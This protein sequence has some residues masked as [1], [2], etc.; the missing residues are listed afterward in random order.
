M[1]ITVDSNVLLSVF[2]KDSLYKRSAALLEKYNSHE[3][4]INDCI[5]LEL[6]VHFE[7]LEKLNNALNTLDVS[8]IEGHGRNYVEILNAWTHYLGN[9]KFVCPSCKQA[10]N[11]VCPKCRHRL[12]F[13]QRILTDFFIGGFALANSAGIITLDP[14]YYKNYFPRLKIFD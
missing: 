5:Y 3:Y 2:A 8:I 1:I 13:R 12:I 4:S 11:P 9:K 14:A 7:N 6:G 10:I